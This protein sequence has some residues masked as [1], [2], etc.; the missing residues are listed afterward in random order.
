M[1]NAKNADLLR[2]NGPLLI[3]GD[4]NARLIYPMSETEEEIV[5]KHTMHSNSDMV[6]RFTQ[7]TRQNR[8]LMVES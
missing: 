6:P 8:D 7:R 5:A 1:T 4:W 3:S 2:N